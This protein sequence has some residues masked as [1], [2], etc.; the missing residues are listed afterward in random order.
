MDLQNKVRYR[1]AQ[2]HIKI[3]LAVVFKLSAIFTEIKCH[4]KLSILG[5]N[6]NTYQIMSTSAQ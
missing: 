5:G 4:E 2:N 1:T 6:R 3:R